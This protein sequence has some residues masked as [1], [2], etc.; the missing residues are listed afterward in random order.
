VT[1]EPL[2]VLSYV[3]ASVK[4]GTHYFYVVTAVDAEGN[5]SVFSQEAAATPL[6]PEP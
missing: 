3:D 1:T 4:S 6:P 5:E 2:R